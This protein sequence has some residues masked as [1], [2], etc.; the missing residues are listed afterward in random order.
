MFRRLRLLI[1]LVVAT[2]LTRP[3]G[4][5]PHHSS[6]ATLVRHSPTGG[7]AT[8]PPTKF[9]SRIL[10]SCPRFF[11][12]LATDF[13]ISSYFFDL[14]WFADC[15]QALKV[16]FSGMIFLIKTFNPSHKYTSRLIFVKY[17]NQTRGVFFCPHSSLALL[18]LCEI[19]SL[20]TAMGSHWENQCEQCS[21]IPSMALNTN[22]TFISPLRF[23]FIKAVLC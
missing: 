21:L 19:Q 20:S 6:L 9:A 17:K 5:S 3:H 7:F 13:W 15:C 14:W 11:V 1:V 16:F 18:K 22:S 4:A 12:F 2:L 8:Q 10:E 23:L